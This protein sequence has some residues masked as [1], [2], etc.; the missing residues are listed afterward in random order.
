[1]WGVWGGVCVCVCVSEREMD[2]ESMHVCMFTCVCMLC[3]YCTVRTYICAAGVPKCHAYIH[4]SY[5]LPICTVHHCAE[6]TLKLRN[7]RDQ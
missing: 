2:T 6:S 3:T 7:F 5:K 1:M 4:V